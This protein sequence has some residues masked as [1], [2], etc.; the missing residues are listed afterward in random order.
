V[1]IPGRIPLIFI[2]PNRKAF[3]ELDLDKFASSV[4]LTPTL[5]RFIGGSIPDSFMGRDLFSRKNLAVSWMI[6]DML[7]VR[8][9]EEDAEFS[10]STNN[11]DPDKQA[12]IDFFRSH[13]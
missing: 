8:S 2:T 10:A 11:S 4:D 3:D 12:M 6:G 13:Y 9:P 7:F 5:V 1:L